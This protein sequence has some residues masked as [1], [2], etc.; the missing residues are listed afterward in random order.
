MI[1]IW[2]A[3]QFE[4]RGSFRGHKGDVASFC[5]GPDGSTLV[6]GSDDGEVRLWEFPGRPDQLSLLG[7]RGNLREV[8]FSP[9]GQRLVSGGADN[10][11]RV[12]D[13][14]TG[15]ELLTFRGH[16]G[17][18]TAV[19]W[20]PDGKRIVSG[21]THGDKS[22]IQVWDPN[23][24]RVE[25]VIGAA[26]GGHTNSVWWVNFNPDGTVLLSGS[27][28]RT[29]RLWDTAT[30]KQIKV[31]EGFQSAVD[32]AAFSPD[33]K[34]IATCEQGPSGKVQV[35]D[36]RSGQVAQE[37]QGPK[38][39]HRCTVFSPDGKR[40]A[41]GTSSGKLVIWDLGT[42]KAL[43]FEQQA[44]IVHSVA[45]SPDGARV[46]S[47]QAN[48]FIN[49]CDARTGDELYSFKGNQG[50]IWCVKPSPDGK[51]LATTGDL[52]I[53][54]LWETSKI[55]SE[56]VRRRALVDA[57]RRVVDERYESLKEPEKVLAAIREDKALSDGVREIA[58]QIAAARSKGL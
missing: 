15:Q 26:Q 2:D 30:W 45:F 29:V 56:T 58:L 24:G 17:F 23:S 41:A 25:Q 32:G 18:V 21:S 46:F 4:K 27:P 54:Q 19:A 51:T 33:G 36:W 38:E 40:V 8:A 44:S 34:W 3:I 55:G 9:D 12:W 1:E 20:S 28:D 49:V 14:R 10:T 35:W 11:A 57:A 52:G 5:F 50:A 13:T 39:V 6:S 42:G 22:Q 16:K 47:G 7:H 53:I 37:F 48:G 31:L 43:Q